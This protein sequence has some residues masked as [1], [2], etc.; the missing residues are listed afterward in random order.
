MSENIIQKAVQIIG[1]Q[2]KLAEDCGVS[3]PTISNW[4]KDNRVPGEYVLKFEKATNGQ[5]SRH[6]IRPDLYPLEN[7]RRLRDTQ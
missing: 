2:E 3:Q 7:K 6:E 1:N 4:K 5:V